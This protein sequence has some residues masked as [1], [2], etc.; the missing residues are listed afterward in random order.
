MVLT[1]KVPHDHEERGLSSWSATLATVMYGG[2]VGGASPLLKKDSFR[3]L[4]SC[5]S[6]AIRVVFFKSWTEEVH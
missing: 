3:S 5:V 4:W 6:K 1:A 2:T